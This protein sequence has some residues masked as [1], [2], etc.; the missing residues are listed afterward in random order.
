MGRWK[1]N[2]EKAKSNGQYAEAVSWKWLIVKPVSNIKVLDKL[3]IQLK[4]VDIYLKIVS[5][6]LWIPIYN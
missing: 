3:F 2:D 5:N 1:Y 4:V 6:K